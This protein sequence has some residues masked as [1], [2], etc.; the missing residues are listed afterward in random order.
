MNYDTITIPSQIDCSVQEKLTDC[1]KIF[2]QTVKSKNIFTIK[3]TV[4]GMI[5]LIFVTAAV[6]A[7]CMQCSV[8]GRL[9]HIPL[10]K[11]FE[12]EVYDT[13]TDAKVKPSVRVDRT[14]ICIEIFRYRCPKSDKVIQDRIPFKSGITG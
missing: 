4:P 5:C 13:I 9:T 6:E 11:C 1:K 12:K 10:C 8:T 14:E 2:L 3:G 7:R